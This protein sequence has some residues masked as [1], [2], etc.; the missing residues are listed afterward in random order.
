MGIRRSGYQVEYDVRGGN[1]ATNPPPVITNLTVQQ[2]A[3]QP[4]IGEQPFAR[5]RLPTT[6]RTPAELDRFYRRLHP[7]RHS[8]ARRYQRM[9]REREIE[10]EIESQRTANLQRA[11]IMRHAGR[12]RNSEEVRERALGQIA[13]WDPLAQFSERSERIFQEA[14]N[15]EIDELAERI[16][17]LSIQGAEPNPFL[18]IDP[19]GNL[20]N[21]EEVN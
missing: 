15:R 7:I 1:P 16:G 20:H 19:E 21:I 12:E 13:R 2:D 17:G 5:V 10:R 4:L 8:V 6:Y 14:M 18:Q 11:S 3:M 9:Q